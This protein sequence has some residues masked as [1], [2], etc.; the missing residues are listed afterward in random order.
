MMKAIEHGTRRIVRNALGLVPLLSKSTRNKTAAMA[1]CGALQ[2]VLR[3]AI[4]LGL[5]AAPALGQPQTDTPTHREMAK[6]AATKN[7]AA[8][9]HLARAMSMRAN[10]GLDD[11]YTLQ[12][13]N[14][15][16]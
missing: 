2:R 9:P 3:T 7:P 11:K 5:L 15:H 12:V 14:A 10:L 13:I 1:A 4:C 16:T 8:L 6:L